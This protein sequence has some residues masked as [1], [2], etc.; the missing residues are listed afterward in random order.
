ML[1]G[2]LL[3]FI[4]IAITGDGLFRITKLDRKSYGVMNLMLSGLM[5]FINFMLIARGESYDAYTNL[6]FMFTYLY[7]GIWGVTNISNEPIG[8]YNLWVAIN[9]IPAGLYLYLKS[10]MKVL[11]FMW[12]SWG[13]AWLLSSV[14]MAFKKDL[15]LTVPILL[16]ILGIFTA[17]VPGLLILYGYWKITLF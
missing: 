7:F 1:F 14:E 6:L 16:I 3:M 12:W 11:A 9:T 17:W 15:K 5:L 2:L 8:W 4:A 13:L 10:D